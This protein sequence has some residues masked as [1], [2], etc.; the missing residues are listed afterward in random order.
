MGLILEGER[1]IILS[2]IL[3]IEDA[4][5][6]MDFKITGDKL[7]ITAF[8]MDIK[9]EGITPAIMKAALTQAK[10]GRIHIL[11]KMLKVCPPIKIKCLYM[12][13]ALKRLK[14]NRARLQKSL[15]LVENKFVQL[16]NKQALKS[17]LMMMA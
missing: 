7:G 2:D 10:D 12:H 11:N 16:L 14:S 4:L 6:D 8:Q 13:L 9:V 5:G 1:F 15:V 17:I 3:G